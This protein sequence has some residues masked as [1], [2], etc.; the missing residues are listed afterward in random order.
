MINNTINLL[1]LLV[2]G[3]VYIYAFARLSNAFTLNKY[4][5]KNSAVQIVHLASLIASCINLIHVS[6]AASDALLFF[7]NKEEILTGLLFA[8]LFFL[9][10][11]V[12]SVVFTRLCFFIVGTMTP[13]DEEDE[14][15]KNNTEIAWIHATVVV[16]LTFVIAPALVKIAVSFIPYP[17][18][19]F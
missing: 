4:K 5:P 14:L 16:A 9:G 15:L 2:L 7:L 17:E 11:W 8:V 12:F 6:D 19:P 10:A 18:M 13:E 3:V 1:I